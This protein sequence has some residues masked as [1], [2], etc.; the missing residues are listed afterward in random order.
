M[1]SNGR[2]QIGGQARN[3]CF[4]INNPLISPAGLSSMLKAHP[5]FRYV[6]FQ[7]E[8]GSN[9]TLHYQ[10][11]IEFSSAIRFNA[12]KTLI[13]GN[14]HIEK[15]RGTREQARHY[16]MK[17]VDGCTCKHCSESGGRVTNAAT[18][19]YGDWATGGSGTR[20]DIAE[21][22]EEFKLGKRI[23]Y[24]ANEYPSV[25][26]R[27]HKGLEKLHALM[28][29]KR[30]AVPM[31]TLLYGK[32]GVGKT[33]AI[34]AMP[35]VFKKDGS[36][37]WFDG[38]GGEDILLIDDLAGKK[39]RITLSFLLNLLDR[40]EVRLPV[41]G[42]FT[43]L[44]ASSIFVTTNI[45]PRLWYDWTDREEHYQALKRRFHSV[46]YYPDNGPNEMEVTKKSFWDDWSQFCNEDE[47]FK[48]VEE[49]SSD[50][51]ATTQELSAH[52]CVVCNVTDEHCQ[53]TK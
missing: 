33:K 14:P 9:D 17:P 41:K 46:I 44:A 11:Y 43:D 25:Y 15:R 19:E 16:C 13:G 35:D 4:T 34:M 7:L 52:Y 31:V 3:W 51:T 8:K 40:Y 23:K 38:Y 29:P 48:E 47:V 12:V 6:V 20:N 30:T 2:G 45:H 21:I 18:H 32:T 42:A 28:Q 27:Y 39:S 1:S 37:Q 24:I 10:G 49:L 50:S 53:C 22:A 26:V 5:R 36:D